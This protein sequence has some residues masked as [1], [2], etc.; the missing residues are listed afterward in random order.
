MEDGRKD[1]METGSSLTGP[2]QKYRELA[3]QRWRTDGTSLWPRSNV[4]GW[5]IDNEYAR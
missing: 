4:I 3:R 5:Q 2:M 1:D